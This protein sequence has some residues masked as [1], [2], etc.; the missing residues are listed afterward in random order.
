VVNIITKTPDR[1]QGGRLDSHV[2]RLDWQMAW[3]P[4]PRLRLAGGVRNL[5]HDAAM[6]YVDNTSRAVATPVRQSP[7]AEIRWRF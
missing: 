4:P 1:T 3:A 5:L 6:E 2:D 7:Y